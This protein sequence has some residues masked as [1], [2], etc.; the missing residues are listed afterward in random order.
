MKNI[1]LFF[2]FGCFFWGNA[3]ESWQEYTALADS[4]ELQFNFN[5]TVL[6]REKAVEF[7]VKEA[8]TLPFLILLKEIAQQQ[9]AIGNLEGR[10]KTYQD[11]KENIEKLEKFKASPERKFQAYRRLYIFAHN[12]MRDMEETN[13][14]ISKSI[15]EHF[16]CK[17]IDSLV[18]LKTMHSLGVISRE[19]GM[20]DN[21]INTFSKAEQFYNSQQVK[22]T[23]MLGSIYVDLA[24]TYSSKFL[25][26]PKKRVSYLKKAEEVFLQIEN[27]NMDYLVGIYP[28]ISDAEKEYGNFDDAI[29][30]L[31][32]GLA[33]YKK[34]KSE[35]QSYR[36]GKIGFKRELQFHHFLVDIY[37]KK[38]NEEKMLSHLHKMLTI[39]KGENLDA[40]ETDFI[41]LAY[42]FIT[43]YYI[44]N[45]NFNTALIYLE[46]GLKLNKKSHEENLEPDFLLEK[47]KIFTQRK[48]YSKAEA[49]YTKV[50]HFPNN[51]AFITKDLLLNK[52]V[53]YLEQ[54]KA[55]PGFK[56]INKTLQWISRSPNPLIVKTMSYDDFN[57]SPVIKDANR[58]LTLANALKT[59]TIPSAKE[60]KM[61]Y[62][63]ALKQFKENFSN[64]LL[65]EELN[66]TFSAINS[67]FFDLLAKK[68][69]TK[70]EE[71]RFFS[72]LELVE[73]KYLFKHFLDNR[74]IVFT[75]QLD[76]LIS[77][78]ELVRCKITY[79]KQKLLRSKAD[80][81]I[82]IR[83]QLFDE[84][85]TLQ[86]VISQKNSLDNSVV[87]LLNEK[88]FNTNINHFKN[89]Y[90]I[91]YKIAND[92]LYRI[93][94]YNQAVT[95]KKL[96]E[97]S[98]IKEQ[99][100]H[101]A[102]QLKNRKITIE[103]IKDNGEELYAVLL[104]GLDTE[105]ISKMFIIPD[106]FLN[107]LPFELLVNQ[108]NYL[109]ENTEVSY[110]VA[111]SL[112]KSPIDEPFKQHNK[113]ALFAPSYN[114]YK[115]SKN[116]L[117]VRGEPYYLQGAI[118]EVDLISSIFE[119]TVFKEDQ[120]TKKTFKNLSDDYSVIHLSMHS[121][122]NDEDSELSSLVFSDNEN[123]YQL[124]ISELYGLHFNS[125]LVVLSACNTGVGN[126]KTGKGMISLQT[127]FTATGVPS[128]LSSL[129]SAPDKATQ[130]IM[131]SF[132]KYL[133]EGTTK[134]RAL[135]L[136]KLNYLKNTSEKSLQHPF[137]W[138]GFIVSGDV[139]PIQNSTPLS[140]KIWLVSGVLLAG[141]IGIAIYFRRKKH[142]NVA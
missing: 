16:K 83:Q 9:L 125:D 68:E 70:E 133:K 120:A 65:N 47:A 88:A 116:E 108:N 11:L 78:E 13:F 10:K 49:I 104:Q 74:S 24:N 67:F 17:K 53:M 55:E 15:Q 103:T 31:N 112:L 51:P 89:T 58:I 117:A 134:S 27:P 139:S 69:M 22:D 72:F 90:I 81:S 14:Y 45:K 84:K 36:M 43:K 52:T 82:K 105:K 60:T 71:K 1:F 95:V 39:T 137:Y 94:Y 109:L 131:V 128:V 113:L 73:A 80:D 93:V 57:P 96:G 54:N 86:G 100:L 62:W 48:K 32:K 18:L 6:A 40:I 56:Y 12:Y 76:S 23:N 97:V 123:D 126:F 91:K 110:A 92:L 41:S 4:L 107:Y 35:S 21:A 114:L 77:Q 129:W 63:F 7:A 33:L 130:E 29:L 79:L 119:S 8:D 127:A 26:L 141:L 5:E 122:L 59:S 44:K 2:I 34:N 121:F 136:A 111:I 61:L 138:A 42:L 37:S 46:K 132:Y 20:F 30:Y 38:G 75:P 87:Q 98:T 142:K 106:G 115:P 66:K 85:R 64:Q 102:Q 118:K 50:E 19:L 25:N 140:D 3:Q 28:M 135:Q 101:Y 99:V 124:Y